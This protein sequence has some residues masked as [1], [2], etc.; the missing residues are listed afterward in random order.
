MQYIVHFSS[1]QTKS[2]SPK[3]PHPPSP[4]LSTMIVPTD[5][6]SRRK[7][8]QSFQFHLIATPHPRKF[9]FKITSNKLI[10][11]RKLE[12]PTLLLTSKQASLKSFFTVETAAPIACL[13]IFLTI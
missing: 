10:L 2:Q 11:S 5:V 7:K 8:V 1:L 12:N 13:K 6:D 9:S 3:P 4:L